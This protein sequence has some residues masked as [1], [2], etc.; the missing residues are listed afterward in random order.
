MIAMIGKSTML[1]RQIIATAM[2]MALPT[3]AAAKDY[4]LTM[5]AGYRGG[6]SFTDVD[7]EQ[8]LELDYSGA[9]SLALDM[10]LDAS[11]QYQIFV[12]H[13]RTDMLL[14]G[15]S[16]A[17]GDK[18]AMDITY[19]H[20][21]GTSFFEGAI[22]KGAYAV[23]GI[24]A[25]LFNP[26]QGYSSELYPSINVG[27]GY[28]WLMSDTLAVRVEARGYATLVNSSGGLFCSGGCVVSIKGDA[29]TQGE[30][31]LG[32]SGRF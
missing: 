10:P 5:Y 15:T 23:G 1:A 6:G 8:G 2:M 12:S 28:Q 30:V 24:G 21:G 9:I 7:T 19:L 20:I 13:Q 11:R 32:L 31:M 17:G 4:A 3:I 27:I 25:T 26:A 29:V 14:E 22:G 18:L 16:S